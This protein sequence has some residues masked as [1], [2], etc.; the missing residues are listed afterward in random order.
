MPTIDEEIARALEESRKSGELKSAKSWGKPLVADPSYSATPEEFRMGFK[1][2]KD[3]GYAPPEVELMNEAA[4]LREIMQ[5]LSPD[6]PQYAGLRRRL[7]DLELKVSIRLE[8]MRS[9]GSL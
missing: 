5:A 1:I 9:T 7:T 2:L 4:S 6:D 8:A 3:A